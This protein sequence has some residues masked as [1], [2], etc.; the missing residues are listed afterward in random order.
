MF[1]QISSV[2]SVSLLMNLN[3]FLLSEHKRYKFNF[4]VRH[5]KEAAICID[6]NN[7]ENLKI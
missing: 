3:A 2:V 1:E 7:F 5:F 4:F 6:S